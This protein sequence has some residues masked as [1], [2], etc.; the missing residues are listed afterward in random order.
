MTPRYDPTFSAE[1]SKEQSQLRN[2]EESDYLKK[3]FLYSTASAERNPESLRK[4]A[5]L[6]G[7][8][9][10]YHYRTTDGSG[11]RGFVVVFSDNPLLGDLDLD[12]VESLSEE[13]LCDGERNEVLI[14]GAPVLVDD[15]NDGTANIAL[16]FSEAFLNSYGAPGDRWNELQELHQAAVAQQKSAGSEA[17]I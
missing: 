7:I 14:T 16:Y 10:V 1:K 11:E 2:R 6:H 4:L 17:E 8:T 12:A 3:E 15:G 9:G 13:D 5:I